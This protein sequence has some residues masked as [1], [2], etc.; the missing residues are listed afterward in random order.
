MNKT[1]TSLLS[2]LVLFATTVFGQYELI[3]KV[4][5]QPGKPIIAYEKYKLLSNDLT[6]IIHEDHSDPVV[7]VQVAYHVGS[8]RE[9]N[10]ISGFAHFF[11]H[12]MFQGSKNVADE[13]H[14]KFISKAGGNCNAFTAFDETVYHNNAPSNFTETLLWMEADRMATCLDGF[15]QAKFESQRNA[16]KNEKKQSYDNQPYGMLSEVL[17]K[18]MFANNTYEWTP[19]GFT[20]DLDIASYEDLRKFFLRWYKPNNATLVVSGDVNPEEV[21]AWVAK[22]YGS[23]KKGKP[24][25]KAKMA[26]PILAYDQ[27]IEIPDNIYLPLTLL[28]WPTVPEYHKDEQALSL[29]GYILAGN[30]SSP[31]YQKLVKTED[32]VQVSASHSSLELAGFM[33]IDAVAAYGGL[34]TKEVETKIREVLADFDKNGV[35]L[36]ELNKAKTVFKT[37]EINALDAV[38]AKSFKLSHWNMMLNKSYNLNDEIAGIDAVT[39]EDIMRVFRTYIKDKKCIV[40]NVV[41]QAKQDEDTEKSKSVNPHGG[42]AKVP[43]PQYDGLTYEPPVDDFDRS[44]KPASKPVNS[45]KLPEYYQ[46]SFDNGLKIIGTQSTE[47]PKIIISLNMEGGQMLETGK[48]PTGTASLT[49]SLMD[50]GTVAL[51]SEQFRNELDKLG[52]N[53]RFGSS[54]TGTSV[55]VSCLKENLDATLKLLEGV[56]MTPR[57]DAADFKRIKKQTLEG[58]QSNKKDPSYMADVAYNKII[59][60]GTLIEEPSDGTFKSVS[61]IK[62]EDVK[63]YYN[64]FYSPNVASIVI[65]GDISKEDALSRLEFLKKWTPKGVVIPSIGTMPKYDKVQ[66]YLIDKPYAPQSVLTV[67]QDHIPYDYNGD[68]FKTNVMYFPL[69]GNFNSRLTMN[70]REEHGFAYSPQSA[71]TGNKYFGSYFWQADVRTNATDSAIREV[72]KEIVKYHKDGITDEELKFT[73][74]SLLLADALRYESPNQKAAF[75]NRIISYNLPS[76]YVSEQMKI[77]DGMT[78]QDVN[79]I[80]QKMLHPTGMTIIVVGHAYK[81]RDSLN[82]LGYGKVKEMT[83]D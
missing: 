77:I 67:A 38:S 31:L 34:T 76:T 10:R 50:E 16:V 70:I 55:Y 37:N 51:T 15:T 19:I 24:V 20:D 23:I 30:N 58:L 63:D 36:D 22:Y 42:E 32:A 45:V 46:A 68:F 5:P 64:K 7:H 40:I 83:I 43:D 33:E 28:A 62:I 81:I 4:A 59:F 13:E 2:A 61:K 49:A 65:S 78:T 25:R 11:E 54:A 79:A 73:K 72:M 47:S 17:F 75:L 57:F 9:T 53:I 69:G 1:K 35:S 74:S 8:A 27:Y 6:L 44:Q 29:L 71:F 48:Y 82:K 26:A 41:P 3:E 52:S 80:A 60:K 66:I 39:V 12:M 18:S 56:L 14:F 21:K